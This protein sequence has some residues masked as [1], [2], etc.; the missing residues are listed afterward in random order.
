M[1]AV[2]VSTNPLSISTAVVPR[3]H[4]FVEQHRE[5]RLFNH[6]CPHVRKGRTEWT[7]EEDQLIAEGVE[8]GMRWEEIAKRLPG[9]TDSAIKNRYYAAMRRKKRCVPA[10][11]WDHQQGDSSKRPRHEGMNQ[12]P[13]PRVYDDVKDD[14]YSWHLPLVVEDVD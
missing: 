13:H 12:E 14:A 4:T 11:E 3:S 9:R 10:A 2:P 7:K 6:P 1:L 5:C 8:H